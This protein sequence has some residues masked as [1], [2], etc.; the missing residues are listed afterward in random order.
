MKINGKYQIIVE[1]EQLVLEICGHTLEVKFK[2]LISTS[3]L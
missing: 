3:P 1:S 2:L